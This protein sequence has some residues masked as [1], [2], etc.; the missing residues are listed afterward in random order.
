MIRKFLLITTAP[1]ALASCTGLA[2]TAPVSAGQAAPISAQERQQGNDAHPAILAEFGGEYN[3]PQANYATRVGQQIAVHSGLSSN[4]GAFD[5]TML[6]SPVNNAFA[7][8]GGYVYVTRQLM[9]LM[10]DEAEL[11]AVL[12]HEVAHVAA[13]HS[14]KRQSTAQRNSIL[15]VL[16][17]VLVGAVAGESQI[18]SILSE[19][20]GTGSQLLTL[21]YSRSQETQSDDL[22]I[23]YLVDAGYDPNALAS[24]LRAL[25]MQNQLDQ[26]IAG[27]AQSLPSWASTHPDPASRVQRAQ[28]RAAAT[29]AIGGTRNRD[30]YLAAI[31]GMLYGDDPAQGVI[32]GRTFLHPAFRLAFDIPQGFAMQNGASAVSITG[33]NAKAQFSTAS[34]NGNLESYVQNVLTGLAGSGAALP[35]STVRRT[36]VNGVPAAFTQ[37]RANSGNGQVDVTVYAYAPSSNRAYHFVTLTPAGQGLGAM[38]SMVQ[39]FRTLTAA[40]AAA[41]KPK[42]VRIV[43]VRSGDTASSLAQRMAFDDYKLQRF[44]VL[45]ALNQNDTLRA[46]QKVKIVTY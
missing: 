10:N 44:L 41:V 37:L 4:P 34:Y 16:G 11:A 35:Q 24:M 25:A 23:E 45:N 21:G 7:I 2:D 3:G 22:A 15:G 14:Q 6:N 5:V 19:G 17:Q 43:T 36:S 8:P 12:G 46:G 18:G 31:D 39:S 30:G 33:P 9:A 38:N 27:N 29:A 1:L 20:I 28:S 40:Q 13:R 26:Q 32:E 42:F